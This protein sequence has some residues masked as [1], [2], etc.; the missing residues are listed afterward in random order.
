MIAHQALKTLVS[1][2]PKELKRFNKF[3]NS[4]YSNTNKRLL[5]MFSFLIKYYPK[6]ESR[7]LTKA[8]IHNKIYPSKIY[9]DS[10]VRNLLSE[11]NEAEEKFLV[12]EYF[13]KDFM[14]QSDY[15]LKALK[16]KNQKEQLQKRINELE[17][18]LS[19][20]GWSGKYFLDKYKLEDHK[21]NFK[22]TYD[23]NVNVNV[24]QN[25]ISQIN[26]SSKYLTL[27]YLVENLNRQI[28]IYLY[29]EKFNIK[30]AITF[31][32]KLLSLVKLEKLTEL[33]ED[34]GYKEYL[35]MYLNLLHMLNNPD[36]VKHYDEYRKLFNL[37]FGKL[38]K[39]EKSF[40]NSYLINYCV[41]KI[42][43]L[44]DCTE[45]QNELFD[46]Y[47]DLLRNEYYKSDERDYLPA[48][49]YRGIVVNALNLGK[50][51]WTKKFM[52]EYYLVLREQDREN[53]VNLGFFLYNGY[54]GKYRDA[55]S[56]LQ[57]I[58]LDNYI[59]KY[60]EHALKLK[61]F[62][63]LGTYEEAI[64][65]VKSF[66]EF[67]K[68]NKMVS[69]YRKSKYMNFVNIIGKLIL[70]KLG[71]KSVEPGLVKNLVLNTEAIMYKDWLLEK[72][73]LE[74]NNIAVRMPVSINK[75]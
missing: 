41:K 61:I 15:L 65:E 55:L 40:H 26:E 12:Y 62:Y 34:K 42:N 48:D 39:D 49:F 24:I 52:N 11:L 37:N 16:D 8:S 73:E 28:K 58:K 31:I 36:N 20:R 6:F 23:K 56:Y 33:L 18:Y 22:I 32:E 21:I 4:S 29:R 13:E 57:K 9:R 14:E 60:D 17:A 46:L 1:F 71:K 3:L 70:Y 7:N 43:Y 69:D 47:S 72:I 19:N 38:S 5:V 10:T 25:R 2:S 45:L 59:F 35:E 44:D 50:F 51:H 53:M 68:Y 74:E 54:S 67:L 30:P 63:E 27:H 66:K 64:C 75:H